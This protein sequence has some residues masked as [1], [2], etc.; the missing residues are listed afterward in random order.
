MKKTIFMAGTAIIASLSL[1]APVTAHISDDI[2]TSDLSFGNAAKPGRQALAGETPE[3]VCAAALPSGNAGFQVEVV[4]TGEVLVSSV[5]VRD[6]NPFEQ[7]GVGTPVFSAFSGHNN[8]HINGQSP[9]IHVF[10]NAGVTTF[11]G[12]SNKNYHTTITDT[13]A[14][15]FDCF[16]YK[17]NPDNSQHRHI[18]APPGLQVVGNTSLPTRTE[19]RAG[20]DESVF[21]PTPFVSNVVTP[22]VEVVGCISPGP[23]GGSWRTQNQYVGPCDRNAYNA[24]LNSPINPPTNSL[25]ST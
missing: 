1:I 18:N 16:V 22:N 2:D 7:V 14:E 5:K 13:F 24:A 6:A 11:P 19:Q 20:P 17:I 4:E 21:D 25:P 12:G 10:A 9:N 8:P 23:K 3:D 15:G